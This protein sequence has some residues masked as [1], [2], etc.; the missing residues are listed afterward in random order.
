[1]QKVTI[2]NIKTKV[3][4]EI[5]KH[6]VS[7]YISTKEWEIYDKSKVIL[8]HKKEETKHNYSKLEDE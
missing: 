4:K 3:K 2:Q 5:A 7:D 8:N 1:M 6:L